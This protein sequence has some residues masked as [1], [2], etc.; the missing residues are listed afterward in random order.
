[1]IAWA[2][3]AAW[4][5]DPAAPDRVAV[6][7][8]AN[9]AAPGTRPLRYAYD[10][11]VRVGE[12]LSDL[13]GF[14]VTRLRD[15]SPGDLIGALAAVDDDDL[16]LLYYSGHSDGD[17]IYPNGERLP[18]AD[19]RAALQRDERS[20]TLG[21]LDACAGAG[22]TRA[23]GWI[24]DEA[25]FV[26][27]PPPDSAGT[28][29]VA[30]TSGSEAAHEDARIGGSYF[31]HHLVAGLKGAADRDGDGEVTLI[32]AFEH[33]RDST[34]RHSALV[35]PTPQF[36]SFHLDLRG[37]RDVVLASVARGAARLVIGPSDAPID[38]V[39][40]ARGTLIVD[41]RPGSG[42]VALALP[43]G[44]YIVRQ[45]GPGP[46]RSVEIA[47][48]QG[49]RVEV[50]PAA[51]VPH[52][53]ATIA[54]KG[55]APLQS[56][57]SL[58]PP[59]RADLR[60][61]VSGT[62]AGAAYLADGQTGASLLTTP[63]AAVALSERTTALLPGGLATRLSARGS[64]WAWIL[65]GGVSELSVALPRSDPASRLIA[66]VGAGVDVRR[67][68]GILDL[69]LSVST[70]AK[71]RW[72]PDPPGALGGV[73]GWWLDFDL[74]PTRTFGDR[75]TVGLPL[76]IALALARIQPTD[77]VALRPSLAQ[78]DLRIG[79][80]IGRA[81]R[82]VPLVSVH[83]SRRLAVDGYGHL[84]APTRGAW[85]LGVGITVSL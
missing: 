47:L 2:L 61:V 36:P 42:G 22:W 40:L 14:R 45:S 18:L 81:G 73:E 17:A 82:A 77:R 20:L 67:D 49:Q 31:T 23:K 32:E 83:P 24:E 5:S 53:G 21:L 58:L 41:L 56:T 55:P 15:P 76:G 52:S 84:V 25:P 50:D 8:G 71:G 60:L 51:L 85:A 68:L 63:S 64:P 69:Q 30:A 80:V 4:A 13:G 37:Q 10:D 59:G 33:A 54:P 19:L 34:T 75:V 9:A 48:S 39:D 27:P 35:A 79:S 6:V 7:V 12:V 74:V 38:V 65:W 57:A 78:G 29:L 66:R 1:M 26:I 70:E 43:A 16:L 44:P 11:A 46:I 3:A 28:A 62:Y 72:F